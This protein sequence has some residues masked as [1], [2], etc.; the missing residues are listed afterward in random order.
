MSSEPIDPTRDQ[1]E[2]KGKSNS[3]NKRA[4]AAALIDVFTRQYQADR[5]EAGRRE[6][7]RI[8][9]EWLT[10]TGLFLAAAVAVFQWRELRSTDTTLK[11]TLQQNRDAL[12]VQQRAFMTAKEIQFEPLTVM[13]IKGATWLANVF[14]ENSGNTPTKNL[15]IIAHCVSGFEQLVD[16]ANIPKNKQNNTFRIATVTKAVFGP[17]QINRAGFCGV[18]SIEA[19]L[20]Q[21]GAFTHLYVYGTAIYHD[22]F[23]Q[24]SWRITQFCF[25]A[26]NF[27]I[28][29]TNTDPTMTAIVVPCV[30]RNCTDEECGE[31]VQRQATKFMARKIRLFR[32]FRPKPATEQKSDKP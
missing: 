15:T 16:P 6:G 18:T 29:G 7:H 19:L 30:V 2:E 13:G 24:S 14:W 8:F 3:S 20:G 32:P 10:I 26:G 12:V 9:R 23:D 17:K 25:Q 31:E 21:F 22:V 28:G 11:E 4:S 1:A 5:K 27:V